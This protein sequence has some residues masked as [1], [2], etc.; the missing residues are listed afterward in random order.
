MKAGDMTTPVE[1]AQSGTAGAQSGSGTEQ[2]TGTTDG[3]QN[4]APVTDPGNAGAQSGTPGTQPEAR[5]TEAELEA[6]RT[7]MRAADQRAAALEAER[8]QLRD[9]DLPALEKLQRDYAEAT[10]ER[11]L[12][13]ERTRTQSLENAFLKDNKYKWKNPAAA[14]KL[15]DLTKVDVQ[16]DGTVTG[17]TAAL[18]ALA[19][20]DSYLID[21]AKDETPNEPTGSTG[22][23]GTNGTR[24]TPTGP[25]LKN[26]AARIPALRSRGLGT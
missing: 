17:L 4:Q 11:D 2:G 1:G 6:V 23:P 10:K 24:G 9:K 21:T 25:N 22:A 15:A 18:D 26:M 20:S 5:Y 8:N 12:L 14:L 19:K 7:R 13:R 16:E 3:T